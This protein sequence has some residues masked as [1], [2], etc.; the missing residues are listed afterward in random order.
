MVILRIT[1]IACNEE[2]WNCENLAKTGC[3]SCKDEKILHYGECLDQCPSGYYLDSGVCQLCSDGCATCTSSTNCL[4][5]LPYFYKNGIMCESTCPEN[6]YRDESG[7]LECSEACLGCYGPTNEECLSC[8]YLKGYSGTTICLGISC[9]EGT[10]LETKGEAHCV[11][12]NTSCGS[13]S[14][15]YNCLECKPEFQAK[16]E[17]DGIICEECPVGFIFNNDKCEGNLFKQQ[18]RN[19]W[20]W[21]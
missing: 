3:I 7:C 5:C 1:L 2:C 14:N 18:Y 17:K 20:R 19:L 16:A 13:C 9:T 6:T 4:T 11:P 10:Y 15:A 8:N 21:A 12:C